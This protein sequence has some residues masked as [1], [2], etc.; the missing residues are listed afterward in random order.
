MTKLTLLPPLLLRT[1]LRT[2]NPARLFLPLFSLTQA[3]YPRM[4]LP[5]RLLPLLPLL[6]ASYPPMPHTINTRLSFPHTG[7]ETLVRRIHN[8]SHSPCLW[9]DIANATDARS[10]DDHCSVHF[11]CS[12]RAPPPDLG[13]RKDV[14]ML[15]FT[16]H[17]DQSNMFFVSATGQPLAIFM[18][19]AMEL[20]HG[21]AT[22]D[23]SCDMLDNELGG[24]LACAVIIA[25]RR[26]DQALLGGY[27]PDPNDAAR[28]YSQHALRLSSARSLTC[29]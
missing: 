14:R 3:A 1:Y 15:M 11:K 23:V 27:T 21:G 8:P 2:T 9:Y 18:L 16:R 4:T 7:Y 10:Y 29:C 22:L 17:R 13:L 19:H 20:P 6:Q 5:V 12:L 28:A 26:N 24:V 25:I